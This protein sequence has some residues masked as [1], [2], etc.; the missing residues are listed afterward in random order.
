M[1]LL[2]ALSIVRKQHGPEAE[3]FGVAL[4]CGFTPLHLQTFLHAEL[5]QFFPAQRVEM[6]AGLY[7]DIPGMLTRLRQQAGTE[8]ATDALAIVLEWPDIDTRLGTRQLGGW[9]P[10]NLDHVVDHA[11]TWLAHVAPLVEDLAQ[12]LPIALSL[13]TLPLPPLFFTPGQQAGSF[14]LTLRQHLAAF[15]ASVA[16]S[17]HVRVLSQ[18]RLAHA[19]PWAGRLNVTSEW[20]SGFPYHITHASALAHLLARLIRNPLPKKGVITD[21]DNTLWNGLV[22]EA[23]GHGVNWDLDHRSQAHG[24]YQQMLR[25]LS[26]E[27]ALLAVAS[28]NDPALVDEAFRRDDLLLRRENL[29]FLDVSW[30]SKA[31]AVGRVL[32]AWNVGAD[33][34]VFIDDDPLELAEVKAAHSDIDCI[35]FPTGDPEAVY[36]LLLHLRDLFGKAAVSDEDRLRQES[37]RVNAELRRAGSDTEGFSEV[38]LAEA[39]AELTINFRKHAD[40]GRVLD[41]INKTNQFNLNGKRLTEAVWR[42][43]L[44]ADNAFLLTA[45]YKDRYGALG[46]IAVMAGR[47]EKSLALI[48]VWVMS[49][50]AFA[51]RVEYQCIATLFAKL[52]TDQIS[53]DYVRTPRNQPI[54]EFFSSMSRVAPASPVAMSR[55]DFAAACP[56]LFHR[57]VE[58]DA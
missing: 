52:E 15:A 41:L 56:K 31:A 20:S 44:Q 42:K 12:S 9:G 25:T 2:D 21:L 24:L 58:L 6:T 28:K 27:G 40:D 17:P 10:G 5:Q 51:R 3:R 45:S 33:S 47:R 37:V 48:D 7:G 32:D 13:P 29:S 43:Y 30:G 38:L 19:S 4:V 54:A 23:G 49:C 46:K 26:E 1:K 57:V 53:F 18:Q 50:R 22:G 34:V 11:A 36:D 55:S 16:R 8:A 14:E 39:D 35:R